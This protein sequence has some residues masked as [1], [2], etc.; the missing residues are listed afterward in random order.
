[1]HQKP[2]TDA[3]LEGHTAQENMCVQRNHILSSGSLSW[4]CR[5]RIRAIKDPALL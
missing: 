3:V 4:E 5:F 2:M 1:M